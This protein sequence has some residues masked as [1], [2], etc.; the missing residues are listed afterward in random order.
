MLEKIDKHARLKMEE[1]AI[2]EEQKRSKRQQRKKEM[3]DMLAIQIAEKRERQKQLERES[4]LYAQ[5]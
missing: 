4:L 2:L 1:Y 5:R 3:E